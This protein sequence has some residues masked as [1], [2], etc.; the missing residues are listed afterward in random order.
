VS[1]IT[2][3]ASLFVVLANAAFPISLIF[4]KVKLVNAFHKNA[5]SQIMVPSAGA[6]SPEMF[7]VVNCHAIANACVSIYDTDQ[8]LTVCKLLA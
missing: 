2:V 1:R 7:T 5:C 8:R 4:H 3:Y 6:T